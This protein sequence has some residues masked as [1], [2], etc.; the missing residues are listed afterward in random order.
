MSCLLLT[1]Q[2]SH[3]DIQNHSQNALEIFSTKNPEVYRSILLENIKDLL[4]KHTN[5]IR[6]EHDA[7]NYS[8]MV[9]LRNLIILLG[10]DVE[11]LLWSS[12]DDLSQCLCE[13][14]T[15]NTADVNYNYPKKTFRYFRD[16]RIYDVIC[17][18]CRFIGHLNCSLKVF[19]YF[20]S[21][22]NSPKHPYR[23]QSAIILNQL[24]LGHCYINLPKTFMNLEIEILDGLAMD[25]RKSYIEL[26][27]EEYLSQDSFKPDELTNINQEIVLG[28]A[29]GYSILSNE[30]QQKLLFT[31]FLLEG[32]GN[33]AI[34]IGESFS[35]QLMQ[36]LLPLFKNLGDSDTLISDYAR[37]SLEKI[38][39]VCKYNDIAELIRRNSDYLVDKIASQ[40]K[41]IHLYPDTPKAFRALLLFADYNVLPLIGDM[42]KDALKALDSLHEEITELLIQIIHQILVVLL[43]IRINSPK[44][45]LPIQNNNIDEDEKSKND[46]LPQT[47]EVTKSI[48]EKAQHFLAS[49]NRIIK[50]TCLNIISLATELL[51][52]DFSS[53]LL[54]LVHQCWK[55]IIN[56]LNENDA[57][58]I[59]KALT[60]IQTLSKYCKDYLRGKILSDLWPIIKKSLKSSY[61][62]FYFPNIQ[63]TMKPEMNDNYKVQKEILST[64]S[65]I[66]HSIPNLST[67]FINEVAR[68]IVIYLDDSPDNLFKQYSIET[69]KSLMNQNIDCIWFCLG[70]LYSL[71]IEG[72]SS[73]E[74]EF[75][76]I[77]FPEFT[78]DKLWQTEENKINLKHLTNSCRAEA[79]YLLDY[80]DNNF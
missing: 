4:T 7:K 53:S 30:P 51:Y 54:P 52:K 3:N 44:D 33:F 46:I 31:C 80:I 5:T 16:E 57:V 70:S 6:R 29:S 34:C 32:I 76:S 68:F 18:I 42:T 77:S 62:N 24:S 23:I 26:L 9:H 13:I 36:V 40:M 1:L 67:D 22:L 69:F 50:V 55:S 48:M 78:F 73:N 58:I 79:K 38:C 72:Y 60:T 75:D 64:I 41:Y 14:C 45:F 17:D 2:H 27:L 56:R 11:E 37:G 19:D 47:M 43:K 8:T 66:S 59:T 74:L 12:I 71:K 10:E 20:I 61:M 35:Y 49:K 28:P 65:I 21:I 25:D 39:S 63:N 15:L